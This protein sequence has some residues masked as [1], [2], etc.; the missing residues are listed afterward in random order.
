VLRDEESGEQEV[1]HVPVVETFGADDRYDLVMVVMRKN[2]AA[3]ILPLLAANRV[4]PTYLFLMNNAEGPGPLVD[5]VGECGAG[6]ARVPPA[7]RQPR[8]PRGAH[9]AGR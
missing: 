1:T 4:V 9:R 2:Q 7:G 5:A 6:A 8:G 3:A